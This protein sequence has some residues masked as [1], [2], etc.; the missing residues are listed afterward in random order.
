MKKLSMAILCILG[1]NQIIVA[2]EVDVKFGAKAGLNLAKI[3]GD[4]GPGKMKTD[5]HIGGMAEI[6]IS[7]KFAVQPE[8]LYSGQGGNF[9]DGNLSLSYLAL[10]VMGKFAIT[11]NFSV[12]AG[13]QFGLL[14]SAKTKK[15]FDD[16]DF[17]IEGEDMG[18]NAVSEPSS[19]DV[20]ENFKSF[21]IGAAI[22]ATYLLNNGINFS[23]R[24]IMGITNTPKNSRDDFKYKN[25]VFQLSVGYYFN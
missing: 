7:D 1:F 13:P 20:K 22:G 8:L 11:E 21:D 2:Q 23:A 18:I 5:F 15:D 10:P 19:K 4:V 9:S 25:S 17:D 12:E 24:Y 16:F 3:T 6:K 14:L